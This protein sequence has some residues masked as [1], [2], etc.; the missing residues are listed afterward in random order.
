MSDAL[1]RNPVI[2]WYG[3]DFTGAAAVMEALTFGGM[4]AVL[5]LHVPTPAQLARFPGYRGI[6]IAGVARTKDPAWMDR[7]LPPVFAF[8]RGLEAPITQYKVCSTFDSSPE[9]GSIGHAYDIAAPILAG[10]WTPLV[11]AAPAVHRYQVFGNLFASVGGTP[12]RLDRHPTMSRHPVTPMTEADLGVHLGRQT[13]APIGLIDIAT[14]H[15]GLGQAALEACLARGDRIVSIDVADDATLREAGRLVWE[16]RGSRL[17]APASQGLEYA[18]LAYWR[19]AGLLAPAPVPAR[20]APVDRIAAVSG[21]CSPITAEQIRW[22]E[23]HGFRPLRLDV[24]K[25]VGGGPDWES[26]RERAIAA[27]LASLSEGRDPLVFTAGG[28]EDPAIGA[29]RTAIAT[30][31]ADTAAVNARIGEG[32]GHVLAQVLLRASL[33]RGIIAGGDTSSYGTS[34]LRIVALTAMAPTVAGAALFQAHS[35]DRDGAVLEVA[36]KGGQMGSPDYFGR[37]KAGG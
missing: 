18:L 2:A 16:N 15:A 10:A 22:A 17:F 27:A 5:F 1:G 14:M 9:T 4:P 35:E 31:G 33:H 26:E 25:A 19:A 6:G 3:D 8:L 23:A 28:P 21:S 12:Y 30:G 29:L 13:R 32:L 7:E 34:A 11:V 37:I 24:V 20:A 36:L